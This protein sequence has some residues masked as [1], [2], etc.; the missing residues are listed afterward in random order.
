MSDPSKLPT[1]SLLPSCSSPHIS[2]RSTPLPLTSATPCGVPHPPGCGRFD[3]AGEGCER[4][5][6][7]PEAAPFEGFA[8]MAEFEAAAEQFR[9]FI[10]ETK[11]KA[12]EAYQLAVLIQKAAAGGGSDVAAALEVCKKAAEATAA[13]GASSD[14]AATSEI[15]KA[16][17]VMVKEVAAHADL[18]QEGSAEEE[19]YRPP[20][21]IPVA[22]A[23]DF[24][25]SMRGLTQRTM[26]GDDSDHM[27]MF[28]KKASVTQTDMKE[29]RGKAKD[30]S[31]DED[32]SS[33]DDVDMVIGGYAQDPYDDSGLE[34]LLQD[35]D[36][37]EKSETLAIH[38]A[39]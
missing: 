35:Q 16:A 4:L 31:I 24:G 18:I 6:P 38:F 12:E 23:R 33:D 26:L 28:E 34:E 8:S 19:A 11:A 2:P 7:M 30:V 13:G 32:K 37:L 22:T 39:Y 27:A 20:V 29:K 21:L 3:T 5:D 10:Q 25:G 17:D 15:C 9:V 36:A 1:P 14:A